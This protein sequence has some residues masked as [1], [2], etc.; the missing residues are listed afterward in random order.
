MAYRDAAGPAIFL[1][2]PADIFDLHAVGRIREVEMH[3]DIDIVVA[4]DR[5]NAVDL[6]ARIGIDVGDGADRIRAAPQPLDQELFGA[7]IIGEAL[8]RKDADFE[9]DSPGIVAREFLDRIETDHLY[10][11]IELD[12]RA[13]AHRAVLDA[14][15]K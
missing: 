8:L 1:G 9:I 13:H 6:A 11:G 14:A 10:A 3:V 12:M 2:F 4:R 7:G 15:L 5:K